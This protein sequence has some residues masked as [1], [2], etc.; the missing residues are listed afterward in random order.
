MELGKSNGH[1]E[2]TDDILHEILNAVNSPIFKI[3]K[4]LLIAWMNECA[5]D[6]FPNILTKTS[7]VSAFSLDPKEF[8]PKDTAKLTYNNLSISIIPVKN[9][10]LAVNYFLVVLNNKFNKSEQNLP[11]VENLAHDLNNIFTS[12]LNSIEL[13]KNKKA[14][15][16][17]YTFLIDNIESNSIRAAE[18]VEGALSKD[19]N[20]SYTKRKINISGIINEV[21]NNIK[22]S[23]KENITFTAEINE[24]LYHVYGKYNDLYRVILNLCVNA[25]EAFN[26]IGTISIKASNLNIEQVSNKFNNLGV[27]TYVEI[28][29]HDNG[30][31]IPEDVLPK[32]FDSGYSTKEKQSKS[33]L[34]LKIVKDIIEKHEGTILVFSK[35]S[36][37]TEFR[38]ILPATVKAH[39]PQS[40]SVK[41]IL[42]AEDEYVLRELLVELLESSNYNVIPAADGKEA[43]EKLK[44]NVNIDLLI[45][46]RKMPEL[47]GIECIQLIRKINKNIP[48]ILA[49]G[50]PTD[51]KAGDIKTLKIDRVI[52]KP[53][54]FDFLLSNIEELT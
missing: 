47:S 8:P 40:S 26:Q 32:I 10:Q 38:I 46:D 4:E 16:D 24:D 9:D 17:R 5:A 30:S 19:T 44:S 23:L 53:Y 20:E 6:A 28:V 35:P 48:I 1:N 11:S 45:I 51:E 25:Y 27:G 31:G 41:T 3:N 42:V 14:D 37:G 22:L 39:H 54:N 15:K 36:E 33:G 34:G 49:S 12:I 18:I 29:V 43:I 2:I 13:I 7:F 50:S 52:N 21:V